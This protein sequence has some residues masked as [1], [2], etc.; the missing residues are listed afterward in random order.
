MS[1]RYLHS[2]R[3]RA[4]S[5]LA[6]TLSLAALA[7]CLSLAGFEATAA[8]AAAPTSMVDLGT[9]SAYAVLS[10]ASVG[11]TVSAAG[12]L[13]TTLRGGLGV[14]PNAQPIGFPPG[15]VT[16][17][18][19]VGNAAAA[20]ADSALVTAY[21]E[22]AAR[23]GGTPLAGALGGATIAP[24]LY[25]IAGA[26]SNTTTVTLDGGGNP[27]AVFVFQVN[28]AMALAA[29]SHVVLVNGARASRVFWQVNGAGAIGAGAGFAGTLMALNAVAVGNGSVV[30]GRAFAL[31]G[32]L[33]LDANEFYSAPPVVIIDGGATGVT[34]DA[35]PTVSGTTDVQ[36][37]AL[38]SV[39]I[40]GQMLTS[41]PVNGAWSVTSALLANGS[42]PVI[43]SVSDGAGNPGSATQ[44]L[45]VDTLPPVVTLDGGPSVT[46]NDPTPTIGGT[47]DITAGTIVQVAIG[48]T[49]LTALVQP[50]GAW[51]VTPAALADGTRTV[52]ASVTDPAGNPGSDSQTLIIDTTPPGVTIAGGANALTNDRTPVVSGTADV[53]P[54][55]AVSVAL[56]DETLSGMVGV[57][58][59]WSVTA[60]ALP[61]GTH[62]V[63]TIIADAAENAASATQALTVDTLAPAVAITGGPSATTNDI[64]PT[65][66]G[67]C[68]AAPGAIITVSIA[69]QSMMTLLQVNGTW[70]AT[71][72]A[73]V[74]GTWAVTASARDLAGNVGRASQLLSITGNAPEGPFGADRG[75]EA[76][77]SSTSIP[78]SPVPGTTRP[79]NGVPLTVVTGAR[80]QKVKGSSLSI[81]TR[82]TT[83]A[84]GGVIATAHG[85]VAI[86]GRRAIRLTTFKAAVDAGRSTTLTLTPRGGKSGRD[87]AFARIK[88]AVEAARIVTA[89][90]TITIVDA[91]GNS[92]SVVRTVRLT[93]GT[94]PAERATESRRH[95]RRFP[96]AGLNAA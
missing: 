30:N 74:R 46:T 48:S 67:T 40:N 54:G 4:F 88:A 70:N 56:A 31:N 64:D 7:G 36:P 71:P 75:D 50:G 25:F 21:N 45:T 84:G 95:P 10:G 14:V 63:I 20:Q 26:V 89:T 1:L 35:T 3:D 83:P 23:T 5:R 73:L 52:T 60:A 32:A 66:T 81:A 58:G 28:G 22:V 76:G 44:Q 57:D 61:D 47:S 62:R 6:T 69:G 16:G 68:D 55:T 39:T 51:N 15:I 78:P 53:A 90:I 43:A 65:I 8:T 33:T 92:R 86:R 9:A 38:V 87:A 19:D 12:A 29:G 2:R 79:F 13:H 77:Q 96:S 24:G 41:S 18:I 37:P 85:T 17:A 82:V 42:Y 91:A 49:V 72:T 80:G 93:A 27:N 59:T 94:K 11:N 34:T